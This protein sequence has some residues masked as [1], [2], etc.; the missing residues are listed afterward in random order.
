MIIIN[1]EYKSIESTMK[2]ERK[3]NL[4]SKI[5]TLQVTNYFFKFRLKN[6]GFL[7]NLF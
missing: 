3:E 4:T 1:K 6:H 5:Q 7:S 2:K